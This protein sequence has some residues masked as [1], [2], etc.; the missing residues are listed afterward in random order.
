MLERSVSATFSAATL[1]QFIKPGVSME[2]LKIRVD[3]QF[4]KIFIRLIVLL[5][6]LSQRSEGVIGLAKFSVDDSAL[7]IGGAHHGA[8]RFGKLLPKLRPKVPPITRPLIRPVQDLG[9]RG[10]VRPIS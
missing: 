4:F 10:I 6:G 3:Q 8:N 5:N 9:H 2:A 1:D 7:V